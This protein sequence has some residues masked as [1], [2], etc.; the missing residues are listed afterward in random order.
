LT[1]VR[2]SARGRSADDLDLHGRRQPFAHRA[3]DR[4]AAAAGF[5]QLLQ[6]RSRVQA[7][8]MFMAA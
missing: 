7:M 3:L 5:D 2:L 8:S 1:F 4:R 6:S